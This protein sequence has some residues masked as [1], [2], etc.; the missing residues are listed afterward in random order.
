MLQ[1]LYIGLLFADHTLVIRNDSMK[2]KICIVLA[3]LMVF[4][5]G[6]CAKAVKLTNEE[7]ALIAEYSSYILVKHSKQNSSLLLS[8]EKLEKAEAFKAE[9]DKRAADRRAANAA[10]SSAAGNPSSSANPGNTSGSQALLQQ[11][12]LRE[13]SCRQLPVFP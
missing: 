4:S 11:V 1:L 10:A 3:C 7:Q 9:Q 6:G 2:K 12:P 5:A 8:K 13:R